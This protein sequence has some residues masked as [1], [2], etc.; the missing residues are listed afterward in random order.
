MPFGLVNAPYF[1][2]RLSQVLENCESFA[3]SYLDDI[4]IYSNNW[5]DHLKRVD[6]VLKRIGDAN[7]TIKRSKCKFTQNHTKYLG[8]VVGSG[9]RT[10]LPTRRKLELS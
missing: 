5:E 3:V 10:P 9:V 7:L 6:E 4:A 8:H 1:F 2:S